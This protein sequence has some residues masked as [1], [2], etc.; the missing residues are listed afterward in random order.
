MLTQKTQEHLTWEVPTITNLL[1]DKM[2]CISKLIIAKG[3]YF[4]LNKICLTFLYPFIMAL[5]Y[6]WANT[7]LENL[8]LVCI[9][10]IQRKHAMLSH[11][12]SISC[13]LY[14]ADGLG[15]IAICT[16][17]YPLSRYHW[18]HGS[19]GLSWRSIAHTCFWCDLNSGL[20]CNMFFLKSITSFL[21]SV[22]L[23]N[24]SYVSV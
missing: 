23:F 16:G 18:N 12:C 1:I 24:R 14:C 6:V 13:P 4:N 7:I 19:L 3:I 17:S 2:Y 9:W 11:F 20:L 21:C 22:E 10:F 15:V 8:I 5:V